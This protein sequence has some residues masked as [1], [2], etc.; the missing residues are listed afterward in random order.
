MHE[1]EWTTIGGL[2]LGR[3]RLRRAWL[4]WALALR[5]RSGALGLTAG[6]ARWWWIGGGAVV[7]ALLLAAG[8]QALRTSRAPVPTPTPDPAVENAVWASGKVVPVRRAQLSFGVGG[9][10]VGYTVAEG[11]AIAAGDTVAFVDAP[12]V[13]AALAQAEA[14]LELARAQRDL[15][16]AGAAPDDVA[17]AAAAVDAAQAQVQAAAAA[18][19]QAAAAQRRVG[20]TANDAQVQAQVALDQA[21]D[22]LY[23]AQARRDTIG[24]QVKR[25]EVGQAEFDVAK[26]AVL[27]AEDGVRAAES[28]L[29]AVRAGSV[30]A[31]RAE[32][33]AAARRARAEAAAAR[34]ALRQ[35][36][37]RAAQLAAGPRPEA[38]AVAEAEVRRAAAAAAAARAAQA[39]TELRAPFDGT[40]GALMFQPGERIAPGQAVAVLGALDALRVE[41][42]DLRETDV[43]RVAVGQR[44]EVTFDGLPDV[45]LAGT[46]RYLAPM[47]ATGQGGTSYTAWVDLG[48]G[49]PRIRWG[50]TAFVNIA[51]EPPDEAP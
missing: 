36:E 1:T 38:L 20:V 25:K 39:Q 21:R 7:V 3:L 14:A 8:G 26:A 17:A 27:V 45:R 9:R 49:D 33:D 47:A 44:V 43:A 24:G 6:A 46:V 15:V 42:T 50:M 5:R 28:A 34:A 31:T 18:A 29:A 2:T 13:E 41:T 16:R 23:G 48:A 32:A 40:V 22:N 51:A 4:R 30:D 35:A 12:D 10:L 19:D 11:E 37:L